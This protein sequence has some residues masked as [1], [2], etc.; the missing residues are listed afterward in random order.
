MW[1]DKFKRML[2]DERNYPLLMIFFALV[3]LIIFTIFKY[4]REE[5]LLNE[6]NNIYLEYEYEKAKALKS[7]LEYY[8]KAVRE[9]ER[10]EKDMDN[11]RK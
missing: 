5:Y 2:R 9:M 6:I 10:Q 4:V 8:R 3:V 1:L 7:D 11:A